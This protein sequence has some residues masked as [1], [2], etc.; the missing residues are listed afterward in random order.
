MQMKFLQDAGISEAD[1]LMAFNLAPLATRRDIAMLGVIHRAALGKGPRHFREHFKVLSD[2]SVRD[3]RKETK[4]GLLQR[5]ALGLVAVY[6]MLPYGMKQRRMVKDFQTAA[7]VLV[8]ARLS[9]GCD[10]WA[11]TFC[12]RI[13]LWRHPLK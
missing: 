10:D 6:N 7:Q 1:A 2:G 3:P 5:S 11:Q 9:D 8:K 12:P 13:P 4:G